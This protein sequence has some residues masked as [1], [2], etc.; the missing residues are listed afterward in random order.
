MQDVQEILHQSSVIKNFK[1][2]FCMTNSTEDFT[3][4]YTWESSCDTISVETA[5]KGRVKIGNT[6]KSH[7]HHHQG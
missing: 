1:S 5:I 6:N 3:L 2:I 7:Y 4:F